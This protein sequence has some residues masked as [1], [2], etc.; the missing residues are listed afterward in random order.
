MFAVIGPI[1]GA[2]LGVSSPL[3]GYQFID[4]R[5]EMLWRA[6]WHGYTDLA[7]EL[8]AVSTPYWSLCQLD[9]NPI[10][11]LFDKRIRLRL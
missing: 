7:P 1:V 3:F 6:W 2:H 11:E 8:D 9:S 10:R 4:L 5:V